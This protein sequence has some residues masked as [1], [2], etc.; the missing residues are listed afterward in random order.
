MIPKN[1]KKRL[2]VYYFR[3]FDWLKITKY[4]IWNNNLKKKSAN[5]GFIAC[6]ENFTVTA[7]PILFLFLFLIFYVFVVHMKRIRK[8]DAQEK[9]NTN[10]TVN[11]VSFM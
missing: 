1:V 2:E 6:N 8:K 10:K 7:S 3:I 5:V 9:V 11:S 4:V